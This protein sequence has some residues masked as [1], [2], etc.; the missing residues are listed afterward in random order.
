[1]RCN[2][3]RSKRLT[4]EFGRGF[5]VA[6]LRKMRQLF[7]M[8][9]IRDAVRLESRGAKLGATGLVSAVE[10]IWHTVCDEWSRSHYRMLMQVE[11]PTAREWLSLSNV[12]SA[13]ECHHGS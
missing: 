3:R 7:R 9:V 11:D 4:A 2:V 1:M 12:P 6:N 10:T 13:A 8:F 5:D